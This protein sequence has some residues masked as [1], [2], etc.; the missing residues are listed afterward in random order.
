MRL[1]N[2]LE[3]SDTFLRRM[4]SWCAKQL[5]M[6]VRQIHDAAFRKARWAWGGLCH[7]PHRIGVRI[8]PDE[9]FPRKA[10]Y[11]DLMLQDR[12]EC[13]IF[14][15][16]HEL[17]HAQTWGEQR[18][19]IRTKRARGD[20]GSCKG[21]IGGTERYTDGQAFQVLTVFRDNREPL[22]AEW[23]QAV[24]RKQA[25]KK[26]PVEKRAEQARKQLKAWER[27]LALAKTKVKKYTAKV[28][29]YEKKE[30]R[31]TD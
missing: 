12:I 3:F 10:G 18:D 24:E 21:R 8:G 2:T 14:L 22:L 16:A 15:T 25:E 27:K 20:G 6:P 9:R 30:M 28:R 13:L 19:I 26:S 29:Y 23:N 4:L 17:S 11:K 1:V 5:K 7:S 31:D